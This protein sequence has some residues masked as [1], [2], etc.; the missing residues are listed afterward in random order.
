MWYIGVVYYMK[1]LSTL[2]TDNMPVTLTVP[3]NHAK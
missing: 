1:I 3:S 2:T